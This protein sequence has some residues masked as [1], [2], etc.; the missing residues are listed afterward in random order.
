[1]KSVRTR[2]LEWV[3]NVLLFGGVLFLIGWAII[4]VMRR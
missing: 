4:E 2:I 3:F 1:M